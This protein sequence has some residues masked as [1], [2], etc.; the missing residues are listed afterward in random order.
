M[1]T[2]GYRL[3]MLAAL[4]ALMPVFLAAVPFS[5]TT[6][7][8]ANGALSIANLV[9][10]P[11]PV[12]AGGNVTVSFQLYNSY[13]NPLQNV[14]LYLESASQLINV[15]PSQT[16]LINSVGT[17]L[18][19][20]SGY[21]IFTYKFHIP[22]SLPAG[23]YTIDA[24]ASYETQAGSNYPT[25]PAES[26]MPINLYVYGTPN[27]QVSAATQSQI[28]PG[29]AFTI[30]LSAVNSGT[31]KASNVSVTMLNSTG[32]R[33]EGTYSFNLGSIYAGAESAASIQLIPFSN[34]SESPH[35]LYFMVNYTSQT[36]ERYSNV[37][38]VPISVA[39]SAPQLVVSV[40]GASPEQLYAGANQTL[41]IE[42]EN[43]GSG[44]AKN[45]S[46]QFLSSNGISVGSSTSEFSMGNIEAGQGVSKS[47]FI[48]AGRNATSSSYVLPVL[49]R[50]HNAD[51]SGNYSETQYIPINMQASAI[52][53]IASVSGA[54]KPGSTDVPVTF[55]I[56][57][58]GNEVAQSAMLSLQTIYPISTVIPS[59]YI[60]SIAPG[61]SENATF[62]VSV[63][64]KGTPG[65]YPVTVYEQWQQPNGAAQQQYSYSNNY[66]VQVEN[67]N[68][69]NGVYY[70]TAAVVVVLIVAY[71]AI[72][73][74]RHSGKNE[75]GQEKHGGKR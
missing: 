36:G 56:R 50:Y 68:G 32:F 18:Y 26:E 40:A 11:Q 60:G 37:E 13:S 27:V 39:V 5:Q 57:N 48:S 51:S 65:N 8:Q 1:K 15:S 71:V 31:D 29:Y 74:L 62:Y 47:V 45:V 38:K 64:A 58:T 30:S 25:L 43:S 7:T 70:Y 22:A 14:N 24:I 34:I 16:F 46:V 20:G 52:F 19:G 4:I 61:A 69:G 9:V 72:R 55:T 59:A 21:D 73:R 17:G 42:I 66:Y 75:K 63:D 6:S 41:S 28:V 3:V 2:I 23:E 53:S 44:E 35:T 10:S 49:L 54:V 33:P 12:V 67:S